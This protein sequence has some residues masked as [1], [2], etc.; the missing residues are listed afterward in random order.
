MAKRGFAAIV[1]RGSD[2]VFIVDILSNKPITPLISST[3]FPLSLHVS[4]S[5]PQEPSA[6]INLSTPSAI[7]ITTGLKVLTSL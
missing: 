2:M 1:S 6:D 4:S 5:T 7:Q 3:V